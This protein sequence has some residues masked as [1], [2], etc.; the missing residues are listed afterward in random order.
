MSR[1][2]LRV[3]SARTALLLAAAFL[4]LGSVVQASF[5]AGS[6]RH[7]P[8]TPR[9]GIGGHLRG[10]LWPGST[11][12]IDITLTNRMHYELWVTR[13]SVRVRVDHA[14]S[15]AGC[16]PR[17]DF[18]VAQLP[19]SVYPIRL[20]ARSV[21][22][23]GWPFPLRWRGSRSWPLRRLGIRLSPSIA[24]VNLARVDQDACKGARLRLV[25][26]ATSRK[27]RPYVAVRAP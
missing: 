24:M 25:L 14:H 23:T 27:H 18:V 26:R 21:Y 1:S 16:S 6:A 2:F 8:R 7:S 5:R 22:R 19:M 15:M 11:Q 4:A 10:P 13:L 12:P 3:P 9:F 20:P 17:R